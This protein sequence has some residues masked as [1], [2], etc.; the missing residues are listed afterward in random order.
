MKFSCFNYACN[1]C[2]RQLDGQP[3]QPPR[4]QEQWLS[5]PMHVRTAVCTFT[6]VCACLFTTTCPLSVHVHAYPSLHSQQLDGLF[7]PLPSFPGAVCTDVMSYEL[8]SAAFLPGYRGYRGRVVS[9]T[10]TDVRMELE[11]QYKTVTVRKEQLKDEAGTAGP[12]GYAG[13]AAA[14]PSWGGGRTPLHPGATPLHPGATPL[15]PSA[16]PLHPSATP[17]HPGKLANTSR[18]ELIGLSYIMPIIFAAVVAVRGS[19]HTF[20]H[21]A[22][23]M[24]AVC[25]VPSQLHVTYDLL[26]L[27]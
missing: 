9:A 25:R 21:L 16:T 24:C 27:D 26:S 1:L 22:S 11:A 5:S 15:H 13:A 3:R 18:L 19:D 6:Q 7:V 2:V 14:R 8:R 10:D 20:A 17:M 4:N 12:S 23:H